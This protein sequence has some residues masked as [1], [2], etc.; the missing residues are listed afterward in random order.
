MS[1]IRVFMYK[2]KGTENKLSLSHG[3]KLTNIHYV[4]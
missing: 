4:V 1:Y 2:I 3:N